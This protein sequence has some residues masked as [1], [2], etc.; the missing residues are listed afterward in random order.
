MLE[1]LLVVLLASIAG[2]MFW[3]AKEL[4]TLSLRAPTAATFWVPP[5]AI[6]GIERAV[7][8]GL[9]KIAVPAATVNQVV[10]PDAAALRELRESDAYQSA[11]RMIAPPPPPW[12]RSAPRYADTSTANATAFIPS[13][14][15]STAPIPR[16]R[17]IED[18]AVGGLETQIRMAQRKRLGLDGHYV[19]AEGGADYQ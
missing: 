7:E 12:Q 9:G 13:F 17:I 2:G 3:V 8:R 1:G 4:R 14:L 6:D 11:A 18:R 16:A 10:L 19:V 5:E 15:P